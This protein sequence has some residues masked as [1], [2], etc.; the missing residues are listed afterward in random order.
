MSESV[1]ILGFEITPQQAFRPTRSIPCV[2]PGCERCLML[3]GGYKF[4]WCLPLWER[5][6]RACRRPGPWLPGEPDNDEVSPLLELQGNRKPVL[7]EEKSLGFSSSIAPLESRATQ[8]KLPV[9]EASES[10][11]ES[12]AGCRSES[13]LESL[14]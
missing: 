10:V 14:C 4:R 3:R 9:E 13:V 12:F 8:E 7:T 6:Y 1:N 2:E 5:G 11:L